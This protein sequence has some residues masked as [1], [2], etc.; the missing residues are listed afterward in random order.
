MAKNV[1]RRLAA[2]LVAD[3]VG[4]SRLMGEDEAGTLDALKAHRKELIDAKIAAHE[5]RIVKLMGDG[6]LAE[7]P[8]VVE[9]VQCAVAVQ[10][11]MAERNVVI[12]EDRRIVFRIGINLGDIIVDGDDIYG[13]GVNVAARLEG[14]AEPGGICISSKVYEEVRDRTDLAF[15]DMGE[16]EF[17]NIDR[18]VHVWRWAVDDSVGATEVAAKAQPL[19]LPDKPSIAVLPFNNLS[20]DPEQEFFADG[21]AEDI[22]TA[23]SR[24]RSLF[25]IDR[26]SS[27]TY[28]GRAIDVIEVGRDLGVRYVVEGSVR[29]AGNRVRITAQLIDATDGKHLWADRF[30]GTLE[31]IFDLQDRITEQIVVAA[32]PEIEAS[33]RERARR[34]PPENLD[35]WERF[36]RGLSHFYRINK[37]DYEEA[38]RLF[39]EA[40]EL[41]PTFALAH[42]YL[43]YARWFSIP[44]GFSDDPTTSL[45]AA[46]EAAEEAA[47]IDPKEPLAH[48]SLGRLYV[49]AGEADMAITEMQTAITSNPNS[50]RSH[51]G[52][53]FAYHYGAG[54]AEQALR[55]Y[56]AAL[57][58]SPRDPMRWMTLMLKGEAL[59]VLDRHNDAI[60]HCRQACQYP[61]SGFLPY[62]NLA[63]AL[64]DAGRDREARTAAERA[65]Q[66]NVD[67]SIGFVRNRFF[68]MQKTLLQ[69]LLDSLRKAGVSE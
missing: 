22:I 27:F 32:E 55:H 17:K 7:F 3:V 13:D 67:F 62:M 45:A 54:Q 6:M 15:E 34:R 5:G 21:M 65:K 23:L 40:V 48:F 52:L 8:S 60:A 18:L 57:R 14:R 30:D 39:E 16:Q 43:A 59:R 38:I 69:S 26:N 35:A 63:A 24:F 25:V 58:L 19:P 2:I 46:R 31:D 53:A 11:G 61:N 47:S 37:D 36:Q 29:K 9:A 68:G 66:I 42:A 1:K 49:Y 64:A 10:L 20:N 44:L 4:Y 41:D 50:A 12:P 33:E 56:D 28:K 51:Y